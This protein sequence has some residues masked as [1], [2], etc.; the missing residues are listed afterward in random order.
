[1]RKG[2]AISVAST[3]LVLVPRGGKQR[4]SMVP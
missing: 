3:T 4:E 2:L 1:M